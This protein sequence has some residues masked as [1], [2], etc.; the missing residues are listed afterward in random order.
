M[1]FA[2]G[3]NRLSLLVAYLRVSSECQR[4]N[5]SLEIQRERIAAYC[6]AQGHDILDWFSDVHSASGHRGRRP[7]FML[8]LKCL[9]ENR[10][11]GLIAMKLDRFARSPIEGLTVA[12]EMKAL[13]KHLVLM[14]INLDTSTA[15]GQCMLTVLLAFAKLER[16]TIIA[17]CGAGVDQKLKR[18]EYAYGHPPYGYMAVR[19]QLLPDPERLKWRA[20]ILEWHQE[21]VGFTA[22][23][24]RLNE[25]GV[26]SARN[27]LWTPGVVRQIIQNKSA[28]IEWYEQ[29]KRS[30]PPPTASA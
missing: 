17:R 2:R 10:A 3:S 16:D 7:A 27:K 18:N 24:R 11:D 12:A 4:E 22:I 13:N 26:P 19:G 25:L 8:A 29:C 28:L 30:Q 15:M 23:S 21:G 5:T 14:D 20:L 6:A 9:R 1:G